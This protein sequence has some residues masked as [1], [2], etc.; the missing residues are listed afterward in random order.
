MIR[1]PFI[2][3]SSH[4]IIFNQL[5]TYFGFRLQVKKN[6]FLSIWMANIMRLTISDKE[7]TAIALNLIMLLVVQIEVTSLPNVIV[8]FQLKYGYFHHGLRPRTSI[9]KHQMGTTKH[10]L[11]RSY[12]LPSL[13]LHFFVKLPTIVEFKSNRRIHTDII[14]YWAMILY[15]TKINDNFIFNA[16]EDLVII[17]HSN[18]ALTEQVLLSRIDFIKQRHRCTIVCRTVHMKTQQNYQISILQLRV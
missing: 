6:D 2:F 17:H 1:S 7:S 5:F 10:T 3:T 11:L 9:I 12:Y 15:T 13:V 4:F 18:M 14:P 8:F 16:L